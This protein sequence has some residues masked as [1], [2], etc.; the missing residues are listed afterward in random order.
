MTRIGTSTNGVTMG[1]L[2]GKVALI[3][4]AARGQGAAAARRFV[5]E[6]FA[7]RRYRSD[8][9][10]VPRSEPGAVIDDL[11]E[12]GRQVL[13]LAGREAET[14]C[15]HGDDPRAVTLADCVREALNDAGL[16]VR[17]FIGGLTR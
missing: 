4:G 13:A 17:S 16:V 2:D 9:S 3:T 1:R 12:V 8:G 10:L 6:G 15:L 5:A 11:E 7:D 14:I